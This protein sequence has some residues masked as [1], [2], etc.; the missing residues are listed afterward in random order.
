MDRDFGRATTD[1]AKALRVGMSVTGLTLEELWRG[2]AGIGDSLSHADLV[3]ALTDSHVLT[4]FE[5]NVVAQAIND[6]LVDMDLDHLVPS[7]NEMQAD[8]R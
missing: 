6:R 1:R 5:Y 3:E 4:D 2:C 8:S 7:A